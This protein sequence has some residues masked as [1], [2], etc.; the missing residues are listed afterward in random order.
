MIYFRPKRYLL[1][2]LLDYFYRVMRRDVE[3][4]YWRYDLRYDPLFQL[5]I[6]LTERLAVNWPMANLHWEKIERDHISDDVKIGI[7]TLEDLGVNLS[8]IEDQVPFLLKPWIFAI[9]RGLDPDEPQ[10]PAAPPK[11]ILSHLTV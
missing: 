11:T 6:T 2:E 8:T 4:G 1:S 3:W 9:Y 5:K 10:E 7:P